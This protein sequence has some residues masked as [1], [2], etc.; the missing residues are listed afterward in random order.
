MIYLASIDLPNLKDLTLNRNLIGR[1][2]LTL[3]E[4]GCIYLSRIKADKLKSLRLC[5]NFMIKLEMISL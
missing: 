5:T 3:S 1:D 2:S 4:V